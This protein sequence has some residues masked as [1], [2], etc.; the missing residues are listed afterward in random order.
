MNVSLTPELE[1]LV[2]DKVKSGMY[3]T[4]SEVIRE[5]LRLLKKRDNFEALRREV[6]EGFAQIDRGEYE[7]Y[8]EQTIKNL[9]TDIKARGMKRLAEKPKTGTQWVAGSESPNRPKRTWTKSG[10]TSPSTR[11]SKQQA[12]SSTPSPTRSSCSASS[13]KPAAAAMRF[14]PEL[15]ASP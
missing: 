4:A 5:A 3:Q 1:Q 6:R 14:N 8:D 10:S 15:E 12:D 2:N 9:A 7:E 11:A 13:Q